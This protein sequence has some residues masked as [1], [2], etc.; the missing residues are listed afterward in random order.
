MKKINVQPNITIRQAMKILNKT[1]VKCLLVVDEKEKLIGTLSDGDIRKALLKGFS[2]GD[3]IQEIYNTNPTVLIFE[4]T[5]S[6]MPKKY[7]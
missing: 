6:K 4:N 3:K 2:I 1:A 5:L 7:F